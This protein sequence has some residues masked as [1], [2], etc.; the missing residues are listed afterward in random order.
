MGTGAALAIAAGALV[1]VFFVTKKQEQQTAMRAANITAAKQNATLTGGDVLS[2]GVS[3][4]ALA[5]GGPKAFAV[6]GQLTGLR[7]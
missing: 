2:A 5:L 7:F 1:L 4:A 3:G 6:A